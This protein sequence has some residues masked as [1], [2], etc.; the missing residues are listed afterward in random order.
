MANQILDQWNT[1]GPWTNVYHGATSGG[2]SDCRLAV[3]NYQRVLGVMK[4][5][6]LDERNLPFS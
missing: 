3:R 1:L 5:C 6:Y 2:P 4:T